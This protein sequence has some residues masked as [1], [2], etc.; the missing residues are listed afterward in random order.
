MNIE[1]VKIGDILVR[2]TCPFPFTRTNQDGVEVPVIEVG[3]LVEVVEIDRHLEE[4]N[5]VK[6]FVKLFENPNVVYK[7]CSIAFFMPN[8]TN[9]V[10]DVNPV[11]EPKENTVRKFVKV[12]SKVQS[13]TDHGANR[14]G[15]IKALRMATGLGLKEAKDLCDAV[16]YTKGATVEINA[17]V[18]MLNSTEFNQ[19]F[20]IVSGH[21][22][23]DLEYE[24]QQLAIRALNAGDVQAAKT[25]LSAI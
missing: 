12:T 16:Y 17:D 2:T 5:V 9:P 19:Y 1:D 21:G 25:I 20:S 6:L 3:D 10:A 8:K 11:S 7:E 14:I 23:F 18:A 4:I 22:Q 24:L 13:D 15:Q